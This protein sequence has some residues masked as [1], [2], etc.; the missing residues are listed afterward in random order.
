MS[1][2]QAACET[3]SKCDGNPP[4][5][6]FQGAPMW[7]NYASETRA[8]LLAFLSA[9]KPADDTEQAFL[10]R[11]KNMTRQSLEPRA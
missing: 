2:F 1:P 9:V 6:R 11:L 4:R 3:H 7:A 8:I 5:I 10:E